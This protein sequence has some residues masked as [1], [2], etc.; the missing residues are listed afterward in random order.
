MDSEH[1]RDEPEIPEVTSWMEGFEWEDKSSTTGAAKSD[2]ENYPKKFIS[3][4]V[5]T[6]ES[7]LMEAKASIKAADAMIAEAWEKLKE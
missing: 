4:S 5:V 3:K 6:L 1:D 2:P 7:D